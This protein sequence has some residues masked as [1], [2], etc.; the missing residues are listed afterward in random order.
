MSLI[1]QVLNE[2]ENRGT[3]VPL[4]ESTIRP[5]P[6]RKRSHVLRYAIL[7]LS[8]LA[9]LAAAKWYWGRAE[10]PV[11]ER[12]LAVV[13]VIAAVPQAVSAPLVPVSAPAETT[14]HMVGEAAS[15]VPAGTLHGKPLLVVSS[16][17]QTENAPV[18]GKP[19]RHRPERAADER[20][21][22]VAGTQV[23]DPE[24]QQ[25]KIVTPQQRA[26]NEFR[27]ANLAVREGRTSDALAGYE[28]ALLL[29]PLHKE[30]RLAWAG[31]LISLKRNDDAEGVL[32]RGLKRDP[33]DAAFAMLLARLQ[34]ER[35]EVPLALTT[36]QKTLPYAEGQADYQA[37]V[38]ALL[39]RQERHDEAIAHY[40]AALKLAPGS[41][42]WL[43]GMGISLQ[44]LHR[45]D[46]ARTAYQRALASNSLNAQLQ[47]FVQN[48]LKSL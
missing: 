7:A 47:A 25:I 6:P 2:L 15:S 44:A 32:K 17:A 1:N 8:L 43:L 4:G 18:A 27:K 14:A 35:G 24:S 41:G 21:G 33:R 28:Q 48:K 34:V 46:E 42:I 10:A 23:D 5:V 30:A 12:T 20:A 31:L 16:E 38:A 26:E 11:A 3:T 37:F 29:D 22:A 13:P 39:Q 9:V 45:N 36:L 40:Q 19:R